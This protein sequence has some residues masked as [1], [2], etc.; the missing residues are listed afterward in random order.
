MVMVS[1][2]ISVTPAA[3]TALR[4]RSRKIAST[5]GQLRAIVDAQRLARVVDLHRLH[6]VAGARQYRRHVRQVILFR[7]IV[8]P[9]LVDVL[10]EE[11]RA[12][13]VDAHIGL[14]HGQL[15]RGRGLLLHH[16]QHIAARI[17]DHAAV[18][19]RVLHQRAH[20]H[21]RGRALGLLRDQ[22]SQRRRRNSGQSPYNTI[23]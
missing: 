17:A 3:I 16:V 5:I 23:R 14:A 9:D 18:A 10:P 22:P 19:R 8:G 21:S 7:R 4:L 1:G 11:I 15:L 2:L 13:A 12:E 6:R 20:Q